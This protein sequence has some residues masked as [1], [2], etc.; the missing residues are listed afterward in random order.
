MQ[1][2]RSSRLPLQLDCSI[3]ACVRGSLRTLTGFGRDSQLSGIE[4][5][6]GAYQHTNQAHIL[7][8]PTMSAPAPVNTTSNRDAP[9]K[10][11]RR[12]NIHTRPPAVDRICTFFV[13]GH[14]KFGDGC[15]LIHQSPQAANA[16]GQVSPWIL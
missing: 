3:R 14:C 11:K 13:R 8:K 4:P 5:E 1:A 12:R 15:R 9:T 16:D 6:P 10:R 7:S 2:R